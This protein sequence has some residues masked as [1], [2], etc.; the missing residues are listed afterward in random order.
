MLDVK[1]LVGE[2]VTEDGLA[3]GSLSTRLVPAI[4]ISAPGETYIAASEVTTLGHEA[5]DHTVEL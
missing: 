4:V 3:T 2:L 1:V 5:T